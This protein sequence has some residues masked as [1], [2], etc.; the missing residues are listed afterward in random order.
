VAADAVVLEFAF[1]LE[2]AVASVGTHL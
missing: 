2:A 1:L